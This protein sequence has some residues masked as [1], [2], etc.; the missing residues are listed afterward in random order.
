MS[1]VSQLATIAIISFLALLSSTI[2]AN[3]ILEGF[4]RDKHTGAPIIG[5][6]VIVTDVSRG[7]TADSLG[8][9]QISDLVVGNHEVIASSA[10][11]RSDTLVAH[12]VAGEKS[13]LEF[14]LEKTYYDMG[15]VIV[16]GAS[17]HSEPIMEAPSS[18]STVGES[19]IYRVAG[20]MQI[21]RALD[22]LP[23]IDIVQSGM[24]DYNVSTRGF[25]TVVN[26]RILVLHDNRDVAIPLAGYVEWNAFGQP[27]EDMGR[28]EF[29]RGPG[30]ALYGA[31]AYSGVINITTPA[32]SEIIGTKVTLSGGEQNTFS[33]DIRQAGVRGVL[34]Y[35]FNFGQSRSKSWDVSRDMT[36][37]EIAKREYEGIPSEVLPIDNDLLLSYGSARIDYNM[38]QGR[39]FT[40][41]AGL[42]VAEN[43][44]Y[45]TGASRF[46]DDKISRPYARARFS[47]GRLYFQTSYSARKTMDNHE[48]ELASG[49]IAKEDSRDLDFNFQT[50]FSLLDNRIRFVT[51]ASHRFRHV[52]DD[53]TLLT[54]V[55]DETFSG[56]FGQFEI[57]I[58]KQLEFIGSARI[59]GSSIHK[60]QYSPKCA[61]VYT[62][63]S[64]HSFR[65]SF[66][67]GFLTP[68]FFHWYLDFPVGVP[69]DLA[70]LETAIEEAIELEQ[71]LP[72]GSL[73]LP[74]NLGSTPILARGNTDLEVEKITGYEFG[75]R[76]VLSNR[77]FI[78]TDI[79]YNRLSDFITVLYPGV[80]DSYP[81]Y[82]VPENTNP[83]YHEI[84]EN[85]IQD[86]LGSGYAAFTTL[87]DGTNA[88]VYSYGNANK[89][90][91]WGIELG[92]NY[93]LG[94]AIT[95]GGS[96]TYFN[97]DIKEASASV[98]PN[99]SPNTP[100]HKFTIR[101]EYTQPEKVDLGL[102]VKYVDRFEWK[103]GIF[104]GE[105]P[106]YTL[107][108]LSG[109]YRLNSYARLN[110]I[111]TNVLNNEHYELFGGS[112]IG[113]RAIGSISIEF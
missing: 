9:F 14:W 102:K 89:V 74:L 106:S 11:Y 17:K 58:V 28:I 97:F 24:T 73:D 69:I 107:V 62:P 36:T 66:N 113:R 61:M 21:P 98:G 18:I 48:I 87:P 5:A 40:I 88:L 12:V 51:G 41:E 50:N 68:A 70:P 93:F 99:L 32:P 55:Y 3:G 112:I 22:A 27:L 2:Q 31:N 75:Y 35:K 79:Y 45:T 108:D 85:F 94:N 34:D 63:K 4:V 19:E 37:E 53:L 86:A 43:T 46:L 39:Y 80:N 91:E 76:G 78:T 7:I 54:D 95:I 103:T 81:P 65:V 13:V 56:M 96:Y 105:V 20:T 71:G 33:Y 42:S 110:M 111:V 52:D 72:P 92:L 23:G 57:N 10:G 38:K 6:S 25:N 8:I 82:H 16:Y 104:Q 64:N 1:K 100:E 15:N 49:A 84:I 44:I 30:S 109:G 26:R 29:I 77:I 60:T 47:S 83:E 67:R 101:L 90:D 59:D